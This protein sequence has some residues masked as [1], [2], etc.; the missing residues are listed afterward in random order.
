M[1]SMFT[2]GQ[3][4]EQSIHQKMSVP[5]FVANGRIPQASL[6]S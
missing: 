3:A 5:S 6:R 2:T 1:L 4:T